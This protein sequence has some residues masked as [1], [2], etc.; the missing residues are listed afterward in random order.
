MKAESAS[1]ATAKLISFGAVG[2]VVCFLYQRLFL[3]V[4]LTDEAFYNALPLAFARG[5]RP[6]IDELIFVQSAS[7]LLKPLVQAFLLLRGNIQ[8]LVLFF[9]HCFFLLSLATT[10][11]CFLHLR[12]Q[13]PAV[14]ALLGAA[15]CLSFWPFSLP[16]LSYNTM[17]MSFLVLG[18]VLILDQLE[19]SRAD[20]KL[21]AGLFLIL[22]SCV[23]YPTFAAPALALFVLAAPAVRKIDVPKRLG[24]ACAGVVSIFALSGFYLIFVYSNPERLRVILDFGRSYGVQGTWTPKFQMMIK[25]VSHDRSFLLI[26]AA[27]LLSPAL[28]FRRYPKLAF[29]SA[30]VCSFLLFRY[31]LERIGMLPSHV[32]IMSLAFSALALSVRDRRFLLPALVAV[33]A[34]GVSAWTSSNGLTNFAIGGMLGAITYAILLYRSLS[35]DK[36]IGARAVYAAVLG[37][38]VL[39]QLRCLGQRVYGDDST[40]AHL[41]ARIDRGAY[42]GLRTTPSKKKFLVQLTQDISDYASNAKSIAFFDFFAAGP[43]ISELKLSSPIIWPLSLSQFPQDRDLLARFYDDP[44]ARPDILVWFDFMP[45]TGDW[46]IDLRH[47]HHDSLKEKLMGSYEK[48]FARKEYSFYTKKTI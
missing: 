25:Q 4:D 37:S 31:P 23:C 14:P 27:L 3:G 45:I 38:V 48:K 19:C 41:T 16:S 8:G 15:I 26:Q 18:E 11:F 42:W 28:L 39:F 29:L 32:T 22:L 30:A 44:D 36:S 24:W 2:I 21:P 20:F 5:R 40:A 10:S 47:D 35:A 9:R 6:F 46:S 13:L 1:G 34:G 12:K 43:L 7:I 17:G 33:I